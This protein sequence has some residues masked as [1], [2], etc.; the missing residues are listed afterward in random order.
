MKMI[1]PRT[2][3][4]EYELREFVYMGNYNNCTSCVSHK[5]NRV[6]ALILEGITERRYIPMEYRKKF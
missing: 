6:L 5:V 3:S 4:G 2:F 1:N